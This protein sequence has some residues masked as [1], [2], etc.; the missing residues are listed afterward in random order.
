[1]TIDADQ[2]RLLG[3]YFEGSGVACRAVLHFW[4]FGHEAV[5]M[6]WSWLLRF[7]VRWG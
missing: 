1:M 3:Q 5:H 6:F 7:A 2:P 4:V